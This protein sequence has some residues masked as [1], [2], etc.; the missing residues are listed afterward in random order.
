VQCLVQVL[1]A[2]RHKLKTLLPP[3]K[4]P[5]IKEIDSTEAGNT[6]ANGSAFKVQ[7]R[8]VRSAGAEKNFRLVIRA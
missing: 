4:G 1:P 2:A 7:L 3:A 5:F 6:V 8:D